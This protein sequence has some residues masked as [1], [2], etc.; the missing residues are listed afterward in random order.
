MKFDYR[1]IP[2]SNNPADPWVNVP[3]LPIRLSIQD[4]SIDMYALVDSGADASLF[5]ASLAAKLG[6][7]L[8]S[9][10]K[11]SFMGISGDKV[12]G[13]FHTVR[14]QVIGMNESIEIAVAFTESPGVGA[15]LGQADFFENYQVKFE[16]YKKRMEINP[17][18]KN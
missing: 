13:Y 8:T 12:E 3:H 9:G 18:K 1:K 15:L 7:N 5:H 11:H 2:S 4:R 6:I 16:R 10:L 14:L 17:A